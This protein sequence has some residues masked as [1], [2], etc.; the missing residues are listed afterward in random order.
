MS[1][2]KN[3]SKILIVCAVIF[4]AMLPLRNAVYSD[5]VAFGQSVRHFVQ[6]GDL[7]VSEYTAASSIFHILWG[8]LFAKI[9][10]FSF[11]SLNISVIILLPVLLIGFYKILRKQDIPSDKSLI[12]TLFFLSIPWIPFLTYTFMSDIPFLTLEILSILFYL[13]Y[14]KEKKINHLTLCLVFASFAFLIRQLGLALLVAGIISSLIDKNISLKELKKFILPVL[15]PLFLLV[16]YQV[17]LSIPG[18]KT[19]PQYFY[20]NQSK[21]AIKNFLPLTDI[22]LSTR[23]LNYSQ[24]IHRVINYTNQAM[25]L[26]F[27][28]LIVLILSNTRKSKNFIKRNYKSILFSTAT[29]GLIYFLDVIRFRKEYTAGFPLNEYE[30]ESLF[31]IPWANLW[32]YLVIIS[33]PFWSALL[34][35]TLTNKIIQKA[36]KESYLVITF[37]GILFMTVIT[38]QSWDRYLLPILPFIYIYLAKTTS[39][40]K[41]NKIIW[42]PIL[43]LILLDSVQMTKLRYDEA[44]LLYNIGSQMVANGVEPSTIDLNRDQG[45]DIWFYYENGIQKQI[46]EVGGDKT[47]INFQKHPLPKKNIKY[48]IYTDRMIKYKKFNIDKKSALIIPF[49]SLFVS[50]K[51][52]FI[53]Y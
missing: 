36:A 23:I 2:S 20:E 5:D 10:G 12:F 15:I 22:P 17:W 40:F 9:L 6:T 19:I 47:K 11:S 8:S 27:P 39:S 52:T 13:K 14:G 48:G 7:K 53:N 25:G 46:A 16:I 4:T 44:G 38:F 33:I 42:I 41:F 45:W 43:A 1:D 28:L 3:I 30:Y 18:N 32:K 31:P 21:E 50:S 49:K 35:K 51:L 29:I 24:Y 26:L 37:L 34:A